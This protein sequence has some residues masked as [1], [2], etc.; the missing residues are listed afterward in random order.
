MIGMQLTGKT[1][2]YEMNGIAYNFEDVKIRIGDDWY[3]L[4]APTDIFNLVA[5][6]KNIDIGWWCEEDGKIVVR[7]FQEYK[8]FMQGDKVVGNVIDVQTNQ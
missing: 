8:E 1:T 3:S 4:G 5:R 2:I 7:G 6:L